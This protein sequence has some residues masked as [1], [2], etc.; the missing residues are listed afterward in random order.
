MIVMSTIVT[1]TTPSKVRANLTSIF[2]EVSTNKKEVHVVLSSGQNVV[3]VSEEE[4]NSLRSNLQSVTT[5]LIMQKRLDYIN[6]PTTKKYSNAED[7]MKDVLGD[8]YDEIPD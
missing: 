8:L 7:M 6:D 5:Q 3:I 2:N 1:A 4:L